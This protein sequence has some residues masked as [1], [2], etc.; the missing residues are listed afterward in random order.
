MSYR[1]N[2]T[3][4]RKAAIV[5]QDGAVDNTTDLAFPGRNTTNYGQLV[6][7]NFLHLL[8][9]FA[10]TTAPLAPTAG[11]M[12]YD[13]ND[14]VSQVK[15]Y[16]GVSWLAVSGIKKSATR[17]TALES[18]LGDLWVDTN[19]QQLFLYNGSNWILVGPSYTSGNVT[20]AI[21][22]TILDAGDVSR[23][24]ITNYVDN[25]P[26]SIYSISE[27]FT[28]K[29][30][31]PGYSAIKPG[32]N[33]NA[34][35]NTNG[36]NYLLHGVVERAAGLQLGDATVFASQLLRKDATNY[37]DFGINIKN[38]AGLTVG[39]DSQLN[40][41]I[42]GTAGVLYHKTSGS[43]IDIRVND[44]TATPATVIRVDSQKFV[45]INKTN[46]TVALDVTGSIKAS[47]TLNI[48]S[49]SAAT[50]ATTGAIITPGGISAT[51]KSY[52][53]N[54]VVII[55]DTKVSKSILPAVNG[56]QSIGTDSMRF[57]S[58]YSSEFHG[59]LFG[60]VTGNL[61]GNVVGTA[62]SL[63]SSTTFKMTGDIVANDV[64]FNGA[65]TLT[66][67]FTTSLSSAFISN[68]PVVA[69]V[70]NS[71]EFII[72]RADGSGLKKVTK[73]DLFSQ[74][75]QWPIGMI[76]PY[77]GSTAPEGWLFCDGSEVKI[78]DYSNLF[79]VIG[80][81]YGP[82]A[83]LVGVETFKVPDLRGRFP[84]GLDNMAN[85]GAPGGS[86]NRVTAIEADNLGM[87]SGSENLTVRQSTS[88]VAGQPQVSIT[89]TNQL[90][91][92]MSPYLSL[93]YII[94]TGRRF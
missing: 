65:G 3:D 63:A 34:S 55:G 75:E 87:S 83:T 86:A 37:T 42:D 77:A 30:A 66:K 1:V 73:A 49:N 93:N 61:T 45:G 72:N 57:G 46:P 80:F 82:A 94:Y 5:V 33:I 74:L 20:G 21:S 35:T 81:T 7:E 68:K 54:D 53:G 39:T 27:E 17:P 89:S 26:V 41:I 12:W 15:V 31:I 56:T 69:T 90:L 70:N 51:N 11:Q 62:T 52:F 67:T 58:V 4:P 71:D 79:T 84:L 25:V 64:T 43:S 32:L 22:E 29:S 23:T 60:N 24:V 40:L 18:N 19:S 78:S 14:N 76:A 2:Y 13:S 36:D 6:A 10:N 38:S 92:V 16:D 48:A 28:P 44:G 47:G 8:E 88:T 59:A 9:N 91:N 85:A 50:N